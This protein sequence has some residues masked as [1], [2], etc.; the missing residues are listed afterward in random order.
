MIWSAV[1]VHTNGSQRSFQP[2]MN[3]SMAAMRCFT[4]GE[5]AMPDR[6]PSDEAKKISTMF[7][8]DRLVRVKC[9]VVRG[10]LSSRAAT[11]GCLWVSWF[12]ISQAASP[13]AGRPYDLRHAAVTLWLNGGVPVPEVAARAGHGVEVLLRVY[14]GCIDGEESVI[15]A[16]LERALQ[17][18]GAGGRIGARWHDR[19]RVAPNRPV[20]QGDSRQRCLTLENR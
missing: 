13:L 6:L 20:L 15:N 1:L 7:S 10:F 12:H 16:H 2:S 11:S 17:A 14:A 5:G 19:T 3:V 18:V 8:H 4:P 9:S